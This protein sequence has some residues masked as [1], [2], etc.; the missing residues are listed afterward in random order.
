MVF[1]TDISQ[2]LWWK[3]TSKG[4]SQV[5]CSTEVRSEQ[6]ETFAKATLFTWKR[7]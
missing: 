4:I 1:V 5:H 7:K 2:L 6:G 3:A